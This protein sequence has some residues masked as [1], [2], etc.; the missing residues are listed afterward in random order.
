MASDVIHAAKLL[1]SDPRIKSD[2]IFHMGW[3][4][5]AIAGLLAAIESTDIETPPLIAGYIAFYPYCGVT[6]DVS[7]SAKILILHGSKDNYTPL[8]P[9]QRLVSEMHEAGTDITLKAFDG[10]HHGFDSWDAPVRSRPLSIT[11]RDTSDKCTLLYSRH[12]QLRSV[13]GKHSVENFQARK[14]FLTACG[15]RGVKIGGSPRYRTAT[16]NL[17]AQFA[18]Q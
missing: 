1:A 15:V 10:A 16:E 5:G 8:A 12:S 6:G 14:A 13:D 17:V 7:S 9:C 11:I 3:S 18:E 4:K 2:R